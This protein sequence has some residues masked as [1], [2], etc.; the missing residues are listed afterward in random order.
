M[1]TIVVSDVGA[2]CN[3]LVQ[4]WTVVAPRG[5]DD[6]VTEIKSMHSVQLT[7]RSKGTALLKVYIANGKTYVSTPTAPD[8]TVTLYG[9]WLPGN[10]DAGNKDSMYV[11]LKLLSPY[12]YLRLVYNSTQSGTTSNAQLDAEINARRVAEQR[13]AEAQD[14]VEKLQFE[15]ANVTQLVQQQEQNIAEQQGQ[16]E[17]TVKSMRT[18]KRNATFNAKQNAELKA[19]LDEKERALRE[20]KTRAALAENQESKLQDELARAKGESDQA[21]QD[22]RKLENELVMANAKANKANQEARR[23]K[24]ELINVKTEAIR[25]NQRASVLEANLADVKAKSRESI[26]A[27]RAEEKARLDAKAK[28]RQANVASRTVDYEQRRT[29]LIKLTNKYNALKVF[30]D[31]LNPLKWATEV[32]KSPKYNFIEIEQLFKNL[33]STITQT[34]QFELQQPQKAAEIEL[35]KD[36]IRKYE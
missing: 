6:V 15:L 3:M 35:L 21:N 27:R 29:D 4:G 32:A 30:S 20:A 31:E 11:P 19:Q 9:V 13:A 16:I 10:Y 36:E 8:K 7:V 2:L 33:Q 18:T 26:A 28:A 1:S 34:S 17:A 24:D 22:A 23:L 12:A 5:G 25:A 14:N